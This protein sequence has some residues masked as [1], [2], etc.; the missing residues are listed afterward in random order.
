MNERN[1][2]WAVL[3]STC[4]VLGLFRGV[5]QAR[6]EV[7]PELFCTINDAGEDLVC[8]Y[9]DKRD[10]SKAFGEEDIISFVDRVMNGGYITVKSK[11]G[12]ER[13][14][15]VDS[16]SPPFNR[17]KDARK[18]SGMSEVARMKLETYQNLE[19]KAIQVSDGLDAVFVQQ[20]MLK[21]DPAIATDK[22]KMDMKVYSSGA[23][24]EKNLETLTAENK[25][26]SIYLTSLL[27]VFR[28]PGS[29][30]GDFPITISSEGTV[31]LSQLQG[32]AQAFKNRCKKKL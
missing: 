31:E 29:C 8:Q 22:C 14:F 3:S 5:P 17:L 24:F 21:Y 15:E 9:K 11:R 2:F 19:R 6:A 30:L 28:E 4:L 13:T 23:T 25:A 20:D 32:L 27:K 16:A 18:S 10:S 12:F 1:R 7:P 26:L